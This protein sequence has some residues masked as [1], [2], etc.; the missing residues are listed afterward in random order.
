[1][2]HTQAWH[3]ESG[4][5]VKLTQPVQSPDETMRRNFFLVLSAHLFKH[6]AQGGGF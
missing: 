6:I 1:M 5:I 4:A 3:R 2:S